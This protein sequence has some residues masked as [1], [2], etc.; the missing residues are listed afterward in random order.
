MMKRL[1]ALLI[2]FALAST[3]NGAL[4]LGIDG[5]PAPGSVELVTDEVLTIE[6]YSSD[7]SSYIGYILRETSG[8]GGLY[9]LWEL[10][11]DPPVRCG[12]R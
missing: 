1:A 3:A 12:Q 8:V 9:N 5:S 10:W 4:S 6:I 7:T 2:V 11:R